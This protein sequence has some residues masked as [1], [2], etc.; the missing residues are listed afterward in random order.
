[1]G[2]RDE[3]DDAPCLAHSFSAYLISCTYYD[4]FPYMPSLW[5]NWLGYA[6]SV[7]LV[8]FTRTVMAVE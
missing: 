7:G 6:V 5:M 4:S 3:T 8:K 1:M 2:S